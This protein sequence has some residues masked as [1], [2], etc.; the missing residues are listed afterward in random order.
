MGYQE[1]VEAK[2]AEKRITKINGQPTDRDLM[3]LKQELVK[4]TA[5]V[6]TSLGGGKHGHLG[7]ILP[8]GEYVKISHGAKKSISQRIPATIQLLSPVW[9]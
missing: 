3:K 1:D 8:G 6:S 7:L 9:Q 5:S 4:I 2:L